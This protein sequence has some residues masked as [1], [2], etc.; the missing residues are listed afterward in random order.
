MESRKKQIII[1]IVALLVVGAVIA[2]LYTRANA[3]TATKTATVKTSTI[4][5]GTISSNVAAGG[6]VRARQSATLNWQNTGLV[7][8]VDV[9]VGDVVTAG[10]ELAALSTDQIPTDVVSAQ[11]DLVAAQQALDKLL[12]S[13]TPQATALQTLENAQTALNN[14][15]N[16]FAATQAQA[17]ADLL[18]AQAALKAAEDHRQ[19]MNNGRAS[20]ATIDN[21]QATYDQAAVHLKS[22]QTV[23]DTVSE[24]AADSPKKAAAT[25]SLY[26]AQTEADTE[27]AL[28]NWY[29]GQYSAQEFAVADTKVATTTEAL[30]T[31]QQAWDQVKNGSD[32]TEKAV[33]EATVTDAQ[34]AYDL[35]K[36]GASADDIASA[37][38]RIY[39]DQT[40]INSMKITA[41]FSGT[42]TGVSVLPH[43][44]VTSGDEAF[45]I[46]DMSHMLIDISIAE[47]DISPVQVGQSATVTFDAI[48]G[49]TY[50]GKVVEIS[51]V[52]VS[53]SGVVTFAV[54]VEM[55]D[56]DEDVRVGMTAAVTIVTASDQDVLM[57]PNRAIRTSGGKQSI[58]VLLEGKQTTVPV[59]V[60]LSNDTYT[61]ISGTGFS[62]DDTVVLK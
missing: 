37:K 13:T 28:L 39:G 1:G 3:Q 58:V 6:T 44:Q 48:S 24:M 23:Y 17:K 26:N 41:P 36:D 52:G 56:A 20:Q 14:Y 34:R 33:L 8:V 51:P 46:N 35:V 5:R 62:E 59:T 27:M 60:G 32:T 49:K 22:A 7:S 57:V 29:V 61:E 2:F 45:T 54:V 30:S 21:A 50:Q 10:Q 31:A 4:T 25:I 42:I 55:T 43:D 11:A 53:S 16:N 40:T 12:K 18:N 9:K 19:A 47:T 15:V 38:S